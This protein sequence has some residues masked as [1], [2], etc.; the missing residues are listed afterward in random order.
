MTKFTFPTIISYSTLGIGP[1]LFNRK[2][3]ITHLK[4]REKMIGHNT[5]LREND[6]LPLWRAPTINIKPPDLIYA[7]ISHAYNHAQ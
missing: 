6:D 2:T 3:V 5:P 1:Y 4:T 7:R